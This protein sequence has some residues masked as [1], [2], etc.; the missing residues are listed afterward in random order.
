MYRALGY[1][2]RSRLADPLLPEVR[3][4]FGDAEAARVLPNCSASV[5]AKYLPELDYA[6]ENWA[7]LSRR[8]I[9]TV[10]DHTEGLGAEAGESDWPGLWG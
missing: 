2:Q 8:H 4:C 7:A 3:R 9:D 5:V 1:G 6:V 10:P